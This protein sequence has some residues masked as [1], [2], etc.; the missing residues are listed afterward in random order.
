MGPEVVI[1]IVYLGKASPVLPAD[2][3]I[4]GRIR[5]REITGTNG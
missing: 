1:A 5:G 3:K 4:S 2:K